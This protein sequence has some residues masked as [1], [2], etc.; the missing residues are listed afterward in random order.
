V[1]SVAETRQDLYDSTEAW[2][3]GHVRQPAQR[4]PGHRPALRPPQPSLTSTAIQTTSWPP[5][6]G[7][8]P[9]YGRSRPAERSSFTAHRTADRCAVITSSRRRWLRSDPSYSPADSE[10][11]GFLCIAAYVENSLFC[12]MACVLGSAFLWLGR[13]G[14]EVVAESG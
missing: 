11:A 8:I 10:S 13:G 9:R 12:R 5:A 7:R 3:E 1:L 4:H 2:R 14:D 6:R